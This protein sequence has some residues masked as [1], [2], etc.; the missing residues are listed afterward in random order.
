M[1]LYREPNSRGVVPAAPG[2]LQSQA[3]WFVAFSGGSLLARLGLLRECSAGV[4][5][6]ATCTRGLRQ[7]TG[8]L[9]GA[10]CVSRARSSSRQKE[11]PPGVRG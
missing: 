2:E 7:P 11:S 1:N 10:E 6:T 4:Q 9:R 3:D 5:A 8:G